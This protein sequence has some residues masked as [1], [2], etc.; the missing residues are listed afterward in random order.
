MIDE[1]DLG[2]RVVAGDG[3]DPRGVLGELAA[4]GEQALVDDLV[5]QGG[6]AGT[7]DAGE[8]DEAVERQREG[9]VVQV[10]FGYAGEGQARVRD[11]D[12]TAGGGRGD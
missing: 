7:G 6:L 1:H 5:E 8:G 3:G 4:L 2:E 10:V 11:G 12:G 9:D